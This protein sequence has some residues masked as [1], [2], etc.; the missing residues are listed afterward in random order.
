MRS[1]ELCRI[2][3]EHGAVAPTHDQHLAVGQQGGGVSVGGRWPNAGD[4][5][6]PCGRPAQF[7][8][9]EV[10]GAPWKIGRIGA[11]CSST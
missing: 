7:S 5:T 11:A 1:L 8:T 9:G 4:R 2:G 3:K 10:A 6:G